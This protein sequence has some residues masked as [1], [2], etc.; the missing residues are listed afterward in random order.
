MAVRVCANGRPGDVRSA[1]LGWEQLL[2]AFD[3]VKQSLEQNVKDLNAGWKGAAYDAFKTH[4]DA[5]GKQIG[6]LAQDARKQDGIVTSLNNAATML[7][8]AQA[9]MPIPACAIDEILAARNGSVN[10]PVGFFEM[11]LRASFYRFP[12]VQW[13]AGLIDW[14]FDKEDKAREVYD[15]VNNDYKDQSTRTPGNANVIGR[16]TNTTKPDLKTGGGGGGTGNLPKTG[17]TKLPKTSPYVPPSTTHQPPGTSTVPPGSGLH[18][19]GPGGDGTSPYKST[20]LAG[21]GGGITGAGL[22]GGSGLGG[23][24]AGLSGTGG[25]PGGGSLGKPMMPTMG[26]MMGGGMGGA[27]RGGAGRGAAGRGAMA[28]GGHG[29]HGGAGDDE[30]TT[31]LQEDDD[32]WGSDSGA[33]GSVLR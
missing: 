1:A 29:G 9:D 30:R 33:P 16:D 15:T 20:G 31:W 14:M 3:E 11:K 7:Q 2:K 24:G 28:G 6:Q 22:G 10:I 12:L 25:L 17:T 4:I 26:G 8:Q 23:A 18:P 32:P 21:A 13:E 27:G 19:Y 5:I